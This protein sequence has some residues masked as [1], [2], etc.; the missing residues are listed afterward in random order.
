MSMLSDLLD[1]VKTRMPDGAS[2][3]EVQGFLEIEDKTEVKNLLN[4]ALNKN[5]ITKTG[6]K[7]GT[8]YLSREGAT[9][10][11]DNPDVPLYDS[12]A[13]DAYLNDSTPIHGAIITHIENIIKFNKPHNLR[14]FIQNGRK[15]VSSTIDYDYDTKRNR[16]TEVNEVIR[17]NYFV[18]RNNNQEC[19]IE[20][21]NQSNGKKEVIPFPGYEE[22]REE[23]RLL[24][25]AK[26]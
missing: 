20:K 6:E 15:I 2:F 10:S 23:L 24:L 16:V 8:R 13:L 5:I 21:F 17:M 11:V 25:D 14:E 19:C 18:V 22:L 7:R 3:S 12:K 9:V 4:D 1:F 26:H